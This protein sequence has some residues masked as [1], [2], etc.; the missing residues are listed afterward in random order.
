MN[1]SSQPEEFFRRAAGV[2]PNIGVTSDPATGTL[3]ITPFDLVKILWR[4]KFLIAALA[5][6][7]AL[8]TYIWLSTFTPQYTAR[9]QLL[10]GEQ[11]RSDGGSFDLVEGRALS[12]PVIEGEL[13]IL[14]SGVLLSRVVRDL[15]LQD[16]PEFNPALRP[17]EEPLLPVSLDD[18][19]E[20]IK[21]FLPIPQ[22]TLPELPGGDGADGTEPSALERA[23]RANQ[24]LLGELEVPISQ[25]RSRLRVRQQG[26][27]FVVAVNVSSEDPRK[28]A[29]VA[30]KV[31]DEYIEFLSDKRFEA[32]QRF[33]NWLEGRVSELAAD[34]EESEDEVVSF[35]ALIESE[36]DSSERLNQQMRELTTKLV[37][38][39]ADLAEAR[40]RASEVARITATDGPLA[41]AAVLSSATIQEYRANIIELRREEAGAIA[42]FG[43]ESPQRATI[44]RSIDALTEEMAS[45]VQRVNLELSNSAD[46]LETGV[47]ALENSLRGLELAMLDRSKEQIELN[48]LTRVAE[49]NR[50]V[51]E[52]FLSRFKESREIQNLRST[53]AEV[54]SYA[55]PNY[56]ATSPRKAVG[57]G[58]A[59]VG[60]VFGGIALAFLLELRRRAIDVTG[61]VSNRLG[62]KIYGRVPAFTRRR[63]AK[64]LRRFLLSSGGRQVAQSA[65]HLHQ[66][67]ELSFDSRVKTVLVTASTTDEA[68][69]SIAVLLAWAAARKGSKCIL[70][71]ADLRQRR[72]S[73]LFGARSGPDLVS[74]LYGSAEL[75]D[76]V[77]EDKSL[78]VSVLPTIRMNA[79]PT[80]LLGT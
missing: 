17:I 66:H 38:A 74:V 6:A 41:A 79:D 56:N 29:G 61:D 51:Y 15:S 42:R 80:I 73:K 16:D 39:R 52:E 55:S 69:E 43:A 19:K 44:R 78:G 5:F 37:N 76:A 60:G 21:S 65:F 59:T 14:R 63:T 27:S 11:G 46:V 4:R 47:A 50:R 62:T 48:Q 49:A 30:N 54:I 1:N 68:H 20:L 2:G 58:L 18:V 22:Q 8:G 53:D 33:T 57:V 40:A 67:I 25:L 70:V 36:A 24:E 13:A 12:N 71:D 72:V 34:L 9:A 35:R 75:S 7:A 45:E 77:I 3:Q 10:L 32:A 31:V 26:S 23:A 64:S 28:A